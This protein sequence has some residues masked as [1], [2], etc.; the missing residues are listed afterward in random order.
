MIFRVDEEQLLAIKAESAARGQEEQELRELGRELREIMEPE[1]WNGF[2][3]LERASR[4]ERGHERAVSRSRI[5]HD[6]RIVWT[7]DETDEGAGYDEQNGNIEIPLHHLDKESAETFTGLVA[8]EV[9]HAW[10]R[11]VIEGRTEAPGRE[12]QRTVFKR[13]YDSYDASDRFKYANSELELDAMDRTVHVIE[14]FRGD[15]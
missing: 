12:N 5:K 11:D 10:Q 13:A 3:P 2:D 4:I 8:H 1:R 9:R 6:T 7:N 14:G 15:S